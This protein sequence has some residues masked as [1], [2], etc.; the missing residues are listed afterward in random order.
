MQIECTYFHFKRV[1]SILK[2]KYR[3]IKIEESKTPAFPTRHTS[4]PEQRLV[5]ISVPDQLDSFPIWVYR[6]FE[7]PVKGEKNYYE[8]IDRQSLNRL[9]LNLSLPFD[10]F[11]DCCYK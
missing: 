1:E 4:H 7:V 11:L 9:C 8:V 5:L 3:S 2:K 6:F 10:T